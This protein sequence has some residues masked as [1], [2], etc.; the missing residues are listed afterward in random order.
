MYSKPDSRNKTKL[1]D[2]ISQAYNKISAK[3]QRGLHFILPGD[4][5]NL[6][7]DT[8]LHLDPRM[9]QVVRGITQKNPP[10]ML[11]PILTTLGSFYQT[12]E[13]LPPL[14]ADPDSEGRASDHLIPIMTPI[15]EI[16]NQ[17]SRVYRQIKIRPVPKSGMQQLQT[18]FEAQLWSNILSEESIDKKKVWSFGS[19]NEEMVQLWKVYC[20]SVLEQSCIVWDSGLTNENQMNLERTQ[21][22]FFKMVLEEKYSTYYEALLTLRLQPLEERRK[23]LTLR[24]VKRS[25]YDGKLRDLFPKR[26]KQHNMVTRSNPKYKVFQA[27]T[28]RYI[29]SP[30][31]V[32]QRALNEADLYISIVV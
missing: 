2:H 1:L 21:K 8:I 3:F 10:R 31:L 14:D 26:N 19:T 16:D 27:N 25:L 18:W 29:N 12:P 11:D 15:D 28:T 13:I 22:T 9:Q 7:L 24:F 6:K 30:I 17:C 4:T 5:N 32:M 23:T 20:Q